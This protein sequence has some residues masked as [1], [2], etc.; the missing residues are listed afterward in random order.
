M[1]MT[2][3]SNIPEELKKQ[4]NWC[5]Y[6][7][8]DGK[9]IP[10]NAKTGGNA[11]SNNESTWTDYNTACQAIE[12]YN[13]NGLGFFFKLPYFGVDIDKVE[14]DIKAFKEGDTN[15][16][17]H[18]FI[19]TLGSYAE[20]SQSGKG[21]HI[22]CKGELPAGA[23]RKGNVEM[24]QTGRFFI[25][26]GNVAAE[27]LDITEC[28][29]EIK[30]LH[31]KYLAPEKEIAKRKQT[32]FDTYEIV[33]MALKSKRG[34][35]FEMLYNGL[36]DGLYQSQSEAD[37]AFCNM[38]A[39]W[40]RR[41]Y[42]KMDSI[43]RSSGLYR[44]KWDKARGDRTYGEITLSKA[45]K[46]CSEV[47]DGTKDEYKIHI[48]DQEEN[49]FYTFDDTG[50]AR[51]FL[52]KYDD[53]IRYSYTNKCWYYFNGSNWQI[54]NTGYMKRLADKVIKDM[55]KELVHAD[56]EIREAFEKHIRKTRN[57][58]GKT[59]MLKE[60][61][62]NAAILLED[63]DNK[64]HL[65]NCESGTVNLH[66]GEI[67]EH[68]KEDFLTKCNSIEYSK[69]AQCPRW[70]KFLSE[71]FSDNKELIDYIQKA[72]GYSLT[73][74]TKEQ[75]VFI[76][77]GT[78][79][80]G[81]S[82]FIDIVNEIMGSYAKNIR[83][84]TLMA[85]KF[86]MTGGEASADIAMLKGARLV[87]TTEPE[88]GARFNEGLLKQLTGE[89]KITARHLYKDFFEYVPEFKLWMATNHKPIVR[90]SDFGIWRR[91]HLIPFLVTIPKEKVDKRLKYK[92]KQELQGI[93]NWA[94]E[95]CLKWQEEGLE[96]PKAVQEA[97]DEYKT[98][99][100]VVQRFLDECT[101]ELK[102][103]TVGASHLYKAYKH[104]AS[105]NSEYIMTSQK[106]GREMT[107]FKE[108]KKSDGKNIYLNIS[109]NSEYIYL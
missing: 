88:E 89:D 51:R 76:L 57:T 90:G 109:L 91:L 16:I 79:N 87:T 108:K 77:Y 37:I 22:I 8:V 68:I 98:E 64:K 53:N 29:E 14:E 65:F 71:I 56:E 13:L 94:I 49:A 60:A 36:W 72:V 43:F 97:S 19:H 104:W 63:F 103:Q 39:F 84:E 50:N 107:N 28:T 93:L 75:C 47:Y 7:L 44:E 46:D 40:C 10:I 105:E 11:M 69:E 83:P 17:I 99:M 25:M 41:D 42:S 73:G 61:E 12:K 54:D 4:N 80:N 32:D 23:R 85:R 15:N 78:G 30:S 26:T 21:I 58:N 52:D 70:K 81:K 55:E 66:T 62:H 27:Y 5:C 6:K 9:K 59:N 74:S 102:G 101:K 96:K 82:V 31:K 92:L 35:Q 24:Y 34:K 100:N 106:F 45:I 20:Y 1:M 33:E 38:L 67:R 18:E 2:S 48:L 3:H 86:G 95:G